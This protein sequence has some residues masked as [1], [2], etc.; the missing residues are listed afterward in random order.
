M[1]KLVFVLFAH[2]CEYSAVS[3][4]ADVTMRWGNGYAR[5]TAI[6]LEQSSASWPVI[7]RH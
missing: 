1:L 6:V 5:G 7:V 3:K 2:T 4:N